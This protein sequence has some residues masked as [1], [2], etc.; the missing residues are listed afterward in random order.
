MRQ[1]SLFYQAGVLD[2]DLGFTGLRARLDSLETLMVGGVSLVTPDAPG[3]RVDPEARFVVE[4]E[5]DDDWTAWRPL[6]P[7]ED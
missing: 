7:L 4:T 5:E 2:L 6:I 1:N 3:E